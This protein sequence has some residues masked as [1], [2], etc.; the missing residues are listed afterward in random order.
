MYNSTL[1]HQFC[2]I[3]IKSYLT[4]LQDRKKWRVVKENLYPG[5]LVLV[6]DADDFAKRALYRLGRIHCLH[7][8]IRKGKEIVRRATVAVLANH[9]GSESGKIQYILTKI[10]P[11]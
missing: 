8:Q 11:V 1:A 5:L 10:A 6:R 9:S 2:L 4:S 7:P 3:W